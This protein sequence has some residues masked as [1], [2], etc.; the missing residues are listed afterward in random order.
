MV[1]GLEFYVPSGDIIIDGIGMRDSAQQIVILISF[2]IQR[3]AIVNSVIRAAGSGLIGPARDMVVAGNTV[4][5]ADR[6]RAVNGA[7][8]G[9]G[10]R[11]YSEAALF[12]RNRIEGVRFHRIRMHPHLPYGTAPQYAWVDSNT[13]VDP[14]EARIFW[15]RD[16]G[17]ANAL[18]ASS[19]T[20]A[21]IKN[22][23][24]Y[25]HVSSA[26]CPLPPDMNPFDATY[27]LASSNLFY[28]SFTASALITQ[29]ASHPNHNYTAGATNFAAWQA[30]PAWQAP[31]D[32]R[33]LI[34]LL[35]VDPGAYNASYEA[36]DAACPG[37]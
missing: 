3:L 37:I 23:L 4:V 36:D 32:P 27:A 26:T 28:G 30:P 6:S 9:Y 35:P 25:A 12:Y 8:G 15:V 16:L 34:T 29:A 1:T 7:N 22:N 33:A 31:G 5:T 19:T 11:A 10:F 13:L 21:I 18:P 24:I 2:E 17:P 20:G 14:R